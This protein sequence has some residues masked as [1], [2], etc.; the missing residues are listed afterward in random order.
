MYT[1]QSPATIQGKHRNLLAS[2]Q[3][4]HWNMYTCQIYADGQVKMDTLAGL[5]NIQAEHAHPLKLL[6]CSSGT[7]T[8]GG[9]ADVRVEH[10]HL[11][12]FRKYSSGTCTTISFMQ[13]FKWNMYIYRI[14]ANVQVEHVRLSVPPDVRVEYAH[15]AF[16]FRCSRRTWTPIGFLQMF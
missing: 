7:C 14:P 12:T 5:P 4:F 1:H 10:V 16:F 3:M 6:K 8:P 11:L 9:P 15:L 13:M 2:L